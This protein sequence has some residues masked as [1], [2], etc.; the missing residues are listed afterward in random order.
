MSQTNS[1]NKETIDR[2]ELRVGETKNEEAPRD[3]Q[4]VAALTTTGKKSRQVEPSAN[5][6]LRERATRCLTAIPVENITTSREMGLRQG[7]TGEEG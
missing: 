7:G 5:E 2:D 1:L 6:A 4:R 3:Q